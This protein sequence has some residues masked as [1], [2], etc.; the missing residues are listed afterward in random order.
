MRNTISWRRALKTIMGSEW[1]VKEHSAVT[2]WPGSRPARST[3]ITN[4]VMY[5]EYM[6]KVM[7]N[8]ILWGAPVLLLGAVL[9]FVNCS[10]E[11]SADNKLVFPGS[12]YRRLG[13]RAIWKV[14]VVT[15]ARVELS[16]KSEY[17]E[18]LT[19]YARETI[20]REFTK[21]QCP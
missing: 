6:N 9:V 1:A 10:G 20:N 12:C 11:D 16:Q 7:A 5:W 19:D 15:H 2:A 3:F 4:L 17:G 8:I 21:V 18:M 14:T 13:E